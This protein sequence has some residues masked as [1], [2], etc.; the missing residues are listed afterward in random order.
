MPAGAV[1][2][3]AVVSAGEWHS[4]AGAEISTGTGDAWGVYIEVDCGFVWCGDAEAAIAFQAFK[5][6]T[7]M[8]FVTCVALGRF[9]FCAGQVAL[10]HHC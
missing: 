8:T 4:T 2:L 7:I 10:G 1:V 6:T 9:G 5:I 3:L